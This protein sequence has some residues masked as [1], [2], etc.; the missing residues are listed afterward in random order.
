ME[1]RSVSY[2]EFS[3]GHSEGQLC[4]AACSHA[5]CRGRMRLVP[6]CVIVHLPIKNNTSV[7]DRTARRPSVKE[8]VISMCLE[9]ANMLYG[10]G[11]VFFFHGFNGTKY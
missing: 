5:R 6:D 3:F 8:P 10:S 11:V 7:S 1:S 2:L 9:S 4:D